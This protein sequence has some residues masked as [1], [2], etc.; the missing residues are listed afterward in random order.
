MLATPTRFAFLLVAFTGFLTLVA[1][2]TRPRADSVAK[3][4]LLVAVKG[5]ASLAIV[6]PTNPQ[7][8]VKIAEEGITGHEVAASP[9]GRTAFV[10]IYGDSGVGRPG[11]DGSTIDV[12]DIASKKVSGKIDLGRGLR[13]HC[14]VFG[15]KDGLLYVTAELADA[16][17]VIDPRTLKV[18]RAIPTGQRESHMLAISSDGRRGYTANVGPGSVSVLDLVARKTITV[19]P[20]AREVQRISI[21]PDDHWVFTADQTQ[22]RL[23]VIDTTTDRLKTWVALPDVAYGTASTHDG[24]W[25]LITQPATSKIAVMDLATFK[26]ARTIDVPP[27]P[28]EILIPPDD[29]KVYISC[30]HSGQVAVLNLD[31]WQLEAPIQTGRGTDGLAWAGE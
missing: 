24:K 14:A 15:P 12:I 6:D 11:S 13:P 5:E 21:T 22:P 28:Q 7:S 1:M 17:E 9:D 3:G 27:S 23:A 26:I 31:S 10:P 16:I 25:L 8:V 2:P 20:V 30:D 4:R 18:V 29:R 19:V